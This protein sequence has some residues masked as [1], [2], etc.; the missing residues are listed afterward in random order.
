MAKA[1]RAVELT[2]AST[3]PI[4]R[5]PLVPCFRSS[6]RPGTRARLRESFHSTV[7]ANVSDRNICALMCWRRGSRSC[8]STRAAP[9]SN[10]RLSAPCFHFYYARSGLAALIAD[11]HVQRLGSGTARLRDPALACLLYSVAH[12][13]VAA[14]R[15]VRTAVS[16]CVERAIRGGACQQTWPSWPWQP[17]PLAWR[18]R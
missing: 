18:D 1:R 9:P 4:R 3:A 12:W 10:A 15:H 11:A 16:G 8:G 13:G 14:P 5:K 6:R 7:M 17:Q 2:F